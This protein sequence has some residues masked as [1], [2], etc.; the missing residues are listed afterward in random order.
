MQK[1]YTQYADRIGNVLR[2]GQRRGQF[3]KSVNENLSFSGREELKLYS[4]KCDDEVLFNSLQPLNSLN[5]GKAQYHQKPG[6]HPDFAHIREGIT[7]HHYITSM[8][9]D[10]S[11][12][13]GLFRKYTPL[14][15]FNITDT[16]QKAA[17]HTCWQFGGYVQRFHGDGLLVYF[18]SRN[19]TLPQ[20]VSNAVNAA[21]FFTYFVKNNLKDLFYE[22]GVENIYTRIGIDTGKAEDVLWCMA[23]MGDCSEI[24]TCSLHTSLAAHMQGNAPNNGVMLGDN[25]KDNNTLSPD[26]YSIRKDSQGKED[27][28]IYRIP[29]ENFNYTQWVFNWERY[30]RN[31]PQVKVGG[32][33][34]LYFG[35]AAPTIVQPPKNL[36]YLKQQV[37]GY[38][39]YFNE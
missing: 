26:L 7:E 20:S 31:H 19:T 37:T 2:N 29:E 23:G 17:I 3:Q 39:P 21:S 38:K 27:R 15:V 6:A 10:I 5:G 14:V 28:Y 25:V 4:S 11:K 13:T 24:T 32:D 35:S 18:G 1:L 16:I 8:F 34:L 9:I 30:L 33:G 12:S 22:Q 36:P